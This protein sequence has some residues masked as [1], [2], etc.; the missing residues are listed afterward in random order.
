MSRRIFVFD[1]PDDFVAGA[2]GEPGERAFYLQARRLSA[3]VSVALEK[4]QVAVLAERLDALLDAVREA[5][6]DVPAEDVAA[7][8]VSAASVSAGGTRGA[9]ASELS[10]PIV[11]AFRVA[12]MTLA[13]DDSKDQVVI[14]ARA[15][16]EDGSVDLEEVGD[17][18]EEGPDVLRVRL[19]AAAALTFAQE[20]ALV[21]AAGRPPCPLCGLPLN[22]EGHI[23]PRRNGYV[24]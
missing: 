23:C 10:E 2:L 13:W 7:A 20:A 5:G 16:A 19:S 9:V 12:A 14:E 15:A 17:D 21:V 3:V 22:P 6:G 4:V 24:N 11:E 1:P 18:D 8:S